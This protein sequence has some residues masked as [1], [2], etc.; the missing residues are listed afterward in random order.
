MVTNSSLCPFPELAV[1]LVLTLSFAKAIRATG[2]LE[3]LS[4]DIEQ[5]I[6]ALEKKSKA[7]DKDGTASANQKLLRGLLEKL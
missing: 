6:T 4:S 5:T 7:M 1:S 2:A 3:T